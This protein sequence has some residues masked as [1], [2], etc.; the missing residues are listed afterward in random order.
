MMR[1]LILIPLLFLSTGCSE[2]DKNGLKRGHVT[3]P[4]KITNDSGQTVEF[5]DYEDL[6]TWLEGNKDKRILDITSIGRGTNGYT[7]A[8][9]I[10]HEPSSNPYCSAC[11]QRKPI[12]KP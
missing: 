3:T 11:G 2:P 1:Y 8:F 12:E 6:R 9:A 5:V 10:T 4:I 7:S